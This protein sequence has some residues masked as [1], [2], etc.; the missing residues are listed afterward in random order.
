MNT[1]ATERPAAPDTQTGQ[2]A[3]LADLIRFQEVPQLEPWA[4]TLWRTPHSMRWFVRQYGEE[5]ATEGV[6]LKVRG[7]WFARRSLL[8]DAVARVLGISAETI[9]K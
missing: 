7:E 6:L 8:A 5:L 9:Q 1:V 3:I 4:A 2:Q